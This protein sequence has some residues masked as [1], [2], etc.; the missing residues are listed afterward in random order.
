[1][2][3]IYGNPDFSQYPDANGPFSVGFA[4][5]RTRKYGNEIQVY[6]PITKTNEPIP[7]DKNPFILPH[8]IKTIKGFLM[9]A[10]PIVKLTWWWHPTFVFD[11]I[12]GIRLGVRLGGDLSEAFKG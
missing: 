2:K 8:D 7:D 11:F 3:Y 9:I 10:F 4:Q 1:M 5:A 12:R 6:Y